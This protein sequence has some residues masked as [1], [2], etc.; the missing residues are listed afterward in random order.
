MKELYTKKSAID[1][2]EVMERYSVG[3]NTADQ[4]GKDAGA[5]FYIGRRKLFNVKKLDAYIDKLSETA[6]SIVKEGWSYGRKHRGV[7]REYTK[8]KT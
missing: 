5:V 7:D 4:I 1:I 8:G 2:N 6:P 3:K